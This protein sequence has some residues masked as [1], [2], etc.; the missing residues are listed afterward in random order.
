MAT[1]TKQFHERESVQRRRVERAVAAEA[2][3]VRSY[4]QTR[5]TR[6]L[7][8]AKE[9]LRHFHQLAGAIEP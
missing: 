7:R 9:E 4:T 5:D 2:R 3:L 1:Q 8:Q 6:Q